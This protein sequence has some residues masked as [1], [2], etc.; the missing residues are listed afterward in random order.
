MIDK[1]QLDYKPLGASVADFIR[2][3]IMNGEFQPGERL[4]QAQ[5]AEELGVSRMP[6]REALHQLE[7]EGLIT[8]T[9][10]RGAH[11]ASLSQEE[12]EDIYYIRILLEGGAIRLATKAATEEDLR[13][14]EIIL[15]QCEEATATGDFARLYDLNDEFHRVLYQISGRKLLCEMIDKLR[16]D[17]RRFRRLYLRGMQGSTHALQDHYEILD[18]VRRCAPNEAEAALKRHL[19]RTQE[20]LFGF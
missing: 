5:I 8:V 18:A 6:V 3:G 12:M 20:R 4:N 19:K 2:T 13:R 14:L 1:N 11:V 17:S 9:P 16:T 10:H 15:E 7:A